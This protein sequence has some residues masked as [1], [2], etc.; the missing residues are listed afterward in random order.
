[1]IWKTKGMNKDLSVSAFNPKFAFEN[2]NLRLST[3][4]GN[5]LLSWVN[6]KG[7]SEIVLKSGSWDANSQDS[8]I[9]ESEIA[10]IPVGTA[11]LNHKLVLFTHRE[12]ALIDNIYVIKYDDYQE[13]SVKVLLL[14][15]GDLNFR[16]E[17]PLETLVSYESEN[18]QKV[19]WTDGRNQPRVINIQG[20][21][22]IHNSNPTSYK[23]SFIF[24]FVPELQ[25]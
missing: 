16:A 18:I 14:Y 12:D 21:Y 10:G 19:Y 4:E 8:P 22:V 2:M 9:C 17:S 20:N 25:L 3:N 11:V 24:D 1:M 6:E 5:T 13:P 7:T 15:S 23:P